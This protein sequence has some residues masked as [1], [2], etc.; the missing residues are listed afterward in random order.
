MTITPFRRVF[1]FAFSPSLFQWKTPDGQSVGDQ[2]SFA[3]R[4]SIS[5]LPDMPYWMR[6]K[7][8]HRHKAGDNTLDSLITP[9]RSLKRIGVRKT[10]TIDITENIVPQYK[11]SSVST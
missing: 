8:S 4:P 9:T 1:R 10:I 11:G 7:Y 2:S 5:G 3:Y 6:Y